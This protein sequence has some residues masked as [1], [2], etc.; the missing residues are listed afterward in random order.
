M[1]KSIYLL[2]LLLFFSCFFLKNIEAK[3]VRVNELDR[4]MRFNPGDVL[5]FGDGTYIDREGLYEKTRRP[6]GQ[7]EYDGIDRVRVNDL[8]GN[9]QT[10]VSGESYVFSETCYFLQGEIYGINPPR[11]LSLWFVSTYG[12]LHYGDNRP[13]KYNE[14]I[15]I[16]EGETK[17]IYFAIEGDYEPNEWSF[18]AADHYPYV[19][20]S[21]LLLGHNTNYVDVEYGKY[22]CMFVSWPPQV[23][24]HAGTSVGGTDFISIN[25]IASTEVPAEEQVV[26]FP[27]ENKPS[28]PQ[29]PSTLPAETVQ[30]LLDTDG[31]TFSDV[32]VLN[33]YPHDSVNQKLVADIYAAKLRKRASVLMQKNVIT[34]YGVNADWKKSQHTIKWKDLPV[35]MGDRIIIVWYTPTF[36]GVASNLQIIQATVVEDG[37]ITFNCPPMGDMS[38][39]SIVKLI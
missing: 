5:E 30:I 17:R 4:W 14:T 1:K 7:C 15:D 12:Y 6:Y 13:I 27:K 18:F 29:T 23:L 37:I 33:Q 28:E 20:Y 3:T 32:K 2:P 34:P 9:Y 19:D 38:V 22:A 21:P 24:N 35:K 10:I 39:M 11:L 26:E 36:L 8:H 25:N 31:T 16:H